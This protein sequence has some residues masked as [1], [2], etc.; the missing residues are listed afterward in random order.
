MFGGKTKSGHSMQNWS[1]KSTH[2]SKVWI[3]VQ[4]IRIARKAVQCSLKNEDTFSIIH[5]HLSNEYSWICSNLKYLINL[6]R[7]DAACVSFPLRLIS[8]HN[9]FA[10]WLMPSKITSSSDKY[11]HLA[12][13]DEIPTFIIGINC[14]IRNGLN[15][16]R[17]KQNKLWG[18]ERRLTIH[19]YNSPLV[20]LI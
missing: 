19:Q 14:D 16:S 1:I 9:L 11:S 20:A 8:T 17:R 10:W 3:N 5:S 7:L 2:C 13:R 12:V 4:W 6:S 15:G 18:N